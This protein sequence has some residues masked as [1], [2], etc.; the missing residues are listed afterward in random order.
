MWCG[1]LEPFAASVTRWPTES[2]A[3]NERLAAAGCPTTPDP[4]NAITTPDPKSAATA[5]PECRW[6]SP[7]MRG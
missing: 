3:A 7:I 2:L 4:K 5:L 6:N 1:C